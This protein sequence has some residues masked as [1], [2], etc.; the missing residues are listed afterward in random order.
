MRDKCKNANQSR[1]GLVEKLVNEVPINTVVMSVVFTTKV[2]K[3]CLEQIFIAVDGIERCCKPKE[4][5]NSPESEANSV[6]CEES[7]FRDYGLV[8]IS[9]LC[10][11]ISIT[12]NEKVEYEAKDDWVDLKV[13]CKT[14]EEP[15]KVVPL[16]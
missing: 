13:N 9:S 8:R 16:F 14:K 1:V 11:E 4:R 3:V 7:V 10:N 2:V 6:P 15:T 5:Q 12:V